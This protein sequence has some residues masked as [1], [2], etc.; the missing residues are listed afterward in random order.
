MAVITLAKGRHCYDWW[1]PPSARYYAGTYQ[2]TY[3]AAVTING[4]LTCA[5]YDH[6]TSKYQWNTVR[7]NFLLL[8]GKSPIY[9]DDHSGPSL[10]VGSDG[11]LLLFSTEHDG[12]LYMWKSLNAEDPSEW[13]AP[14]V[15]D[16][17]AC[18]YAKPLLVGSTLYLFYRKQVSGLDR[19]QYYRTSTDNGDTW[20]GATELVN[21]SAA[22]LRPYLVI[23]K[24]TV[25]SDRVEIGFITSNP[26]D[27]TGID[28]YYFYFRPSDGKKFNIA[29]TEIASGVPVTPTTTNL[30]K[31]YDGSS[32]EAWLSDIRNDSNGYPCILFPKWVTQATDH[33][34]MDVRWNGSSWD[35]TQIAAGGAGLSAGSLLPGGAVYDPADSTI[36]VCSPESGGVRNIEQFS[37]SGGVWS[38]DGTIGSTGGKRIRPLFVEGY[39]SAFD[40]IWMNATSPLFYTGSLND[41]WPSNGWNTDLEARTT[42]TP[43]SAAGVQAEVISVKTR[44]STGTQF[45]P[46][47]FRPKLILVFGTALFNGAAAGGRFFVGA[48][49]D[50]ADPPNQ[51]CFGVSESIASE[52]THRYRSGSLVFGN[53]LGDTTTSFDINIAAGGITD[54]GFTLT[55]NTTTSITATFL[56]LGGDVSA[57][58]GTFDTGTGTTDLAVTGVGFEPKVV[59]GVVTRADLTAGVT[60]ANRFALGVSTGPSS[61]VCLSSM[62]LGAATSNETGLLHESRWLAPINAAGSTAYHFEFDV[63]SLDS[64]GFTIERVAAAP[65]DERC[66]YV[67]I[68]GAIQVALSAYNA[69]T[70]TGSQTRSGFGFRPEAVVVLSA[71]RVTSDTPTDHA[72]DMVGIAVGPSAESCAL[73]ASTDN[74]GTWDSV[75]NADET[76]FIVH[77][78]GATPTVNASALFTGMSDTGYTEYWDVASAT[79]RRVVAL[80]LASQGPITP[81]LGTLTLAANAPSVLRGTVLTPKTAVRGV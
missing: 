7:T 26:D 40:L 30:N 65:A 34:Y 38:S 72:N 10:H 19:P 21:N 17:G 68:G 9:S 36:V 75:R 39:A 50:A 80:A 8:E 51:W 53:T 6:Q 77:A 62:G 1:Q 81:S 43:V 59:I 57:K 24:N 33:R 18:A 28:V 63:K 22:T 27:T 13:A 46:T 14:V 66:G 55:A 70:A 48:A 71:A 11:K 29:G 12:P 32:L 37:L 56:I 35:T 67:A 42:I 4:D 41:E 61:R 54:N 64:G 52:L 45:I 5:Y 23:A 58:V 15:V 20:S 44:T 47:S 76:H 31:V 74:L 69:P 2:R 79:A 25:I 3:I 73:F 60:T 78:S 16:S 49:D